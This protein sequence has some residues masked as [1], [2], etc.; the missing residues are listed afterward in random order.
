MSG[1]DQNANSVYLQDFES[2]AKAREA[3]YQ[4]AILSLVGIQTVEGLR[5]LR[6]VVRFSREG[7]SDAK[8]TSE[9]PLDYGTLVFLRLAQSVDRAIQFV[10]DASTKGELLEVQ[11]FHIQCGPFVSPYLV[12]GLPHPDWPE[13]IGLGRIFDWPSRDFTWW[14]GG[15]SDPHGLRDPFGILVSPNHPPVINPTQATDDWTG[16]PWGNRISPSPN[17]IYVVL[18]DF[19]VRIQ[20]VLITDTGVE[21][22]LNGLERESSDIIFQA[23]AGDRRREEPLEVRS[24]RNGSVEVAIS[25]PSNAFHFFVLEK[26]SGRVLDWID[27]DVERPLPA[28]VR[29]ESLGLRV[30][31]LLEGGET[32]FVEWKAAVGEAEAI[33]EFF[34]SVTAFANSNA[35][36]ILVGVDD[37]GTV[38][39]LQGLTPE[40]VRSRITDL[41]E[42][43]CEPVPEGIQFQEAEYSGKKVLILQVPKGQNPPYIL[44]RDGP[45]SRTEIYVRRGDKDRPARRPEIDDFYEARLAQRGQVWR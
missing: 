18:P 26:S 19:R 5:L 31:Q 24:V 36:T 30:A 21:V 44:R 35:G 27:F 20:S 10:K 38:V 43:R 7:D 37:H 34:E 14:S 39:G 6:G 15:P 13:A 25:K 16:L 4:R 23:T 17:L 12:G 40:S 29:Y 3:T 1:A 41:A 45:T 32:Q 33:G 28:Q 8:D 11:G 42:T 2:T 22:E 9:G